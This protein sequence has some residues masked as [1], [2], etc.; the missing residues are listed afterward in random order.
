[1]VR[2]CLPVILG[3]SMLGAM[4]QPAVAQAVLASGRQAAVALAPQLNFSADEMALAEAVADSPQ[5]ASFYGS[6]GLR[7]I[8][9]GADGARLRDALREVA[10]TAQRHG[11][12]AGRYRPRDPA[13]AGQG[14]ESE[15]IHAQILLRYDLDMTGGAIR[16]ADADPQIR[17]QVNRPDAARLIRDFVAAPDPAAY[18]AGLAPDAPAYLALQDALAGSADLTVPDGIAPAPVALWR[19]GM[20][21]DGVV[22]LRTRLA[23]IGFSAPS[24]DPSVYDA[25]LS[26]A[27]AEY[28]RAA[29]L[30]SDG[31]AGPDTI[32]R[33]NGDLPG[34][35][36]W[37][38]RM[39]AVALERMRWMGG[40]DLQ[41]R[42]VWVNIPEFTAR[43][44]D[45]GDEIFRTRVVVGKTAPDMRTPEFSDRMEYV[46]V[47]PRWNVPRSITV[48]EYLPRLKANRH[49]VSHLD[50]VDGRGNV[51]PRS[52][53]DFSRYT[54]ANFPYRM[55][56][57][58][59]DDNALG[60]VKFI[61]PN[62][63]NIYLHD[64]P[65]KHLFRNSSRAYS[66]GCVRVGDP[67]DLATQLLSP[68]SDD[69]RG[70]F[71]RAL[72]SG[73]ERWLALTPNVPVHLV[74]FT[75]FPDQSGQIRFH[76]DIYG[77]DAAVWDRLQALGLDSVGESD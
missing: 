50:V 71:Q 64:T 47:N 4:P 46:V 41:A 24:D 70:L 40:E 66:H 12:P 37:R 54:A 20:S 11:L 57:K 32:G 67:F 3:L 36:D 59:S 10:A 68:Q 7:P 31:V 38:S 42:H 72:D 63:W 30:H 17:R 33:L 35:G 45:R 39:I 18:L 27:V 62:P 19:I 25:A 22:A 73:R 76:E 14:L 26:G 53:I 61:F 65:T 58:P 29:G 8:F 23:S 52:R 51:I 16:P 74:Y 21:G 69:P 28:Q 56:Q 75:A 2:F 55:R 48:K 77:R 6:N 9:Q 43:I 13:A 49:A 5:L 60:L 34:L 44:M 15:V 1:M